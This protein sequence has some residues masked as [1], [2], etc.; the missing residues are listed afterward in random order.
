M[1]KGINYSFFNIPLIAV[2]MFLYEEQTKQQ[3]V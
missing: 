1:K 2:E 3:T